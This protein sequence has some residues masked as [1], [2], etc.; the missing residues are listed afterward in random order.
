[1][2]IVG[3]EASNS[4][5]GT[6]SAA[7]VLGRITTGGFSVSRGA[8]HG[9]GVVGAVRLLGYIERTTGRGDDSFSSNPGRVVR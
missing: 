7:P 3:A 1:M 2:A 8:C 9:I 5:D 4:N 6:G